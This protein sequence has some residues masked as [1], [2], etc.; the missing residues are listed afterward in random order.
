MRT[1]VSHRPQLHSVSP[2]SR[3][4]NFGWGTRGWNVE[5]HG[6]ERHVPTPGV[7]NYISPPSFFLPTQRGRR[8]KV[9]L[10]SI[11]DARAVGC[12]ESLGL[13]MYV[14]TYASGYVA[15]AAV[16]TF[17]LS[18]FP[19]TPELFDVGMYDSPHARVGITVRKLCT[20][21]SRWEYALFSPNIPELE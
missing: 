19:R 4:P 6:S 12:R 13:C 10:D 11:I 20:Y 2:R 18:P 7:M 15:P 8:A 3:K 9:P 16:T 5:D 14:C 17:L 21:R 1:A